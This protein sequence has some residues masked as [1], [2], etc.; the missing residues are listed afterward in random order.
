MEIN[1]SMEK[2]DIKYNITL[3]QP[4]IGEKSDFYEK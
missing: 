3:D 2:I 4:L 1:T